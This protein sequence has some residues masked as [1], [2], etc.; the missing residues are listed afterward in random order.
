MFG[1]IGGSGFY[2]LEDLE[3]ENINNRIEIVETKYG[4]VK[5]NII[6]IENK[7][8]KIAFIPRHKKNHSIPPHKINYKANIE[9]MKKIGV[10]EAVGVYAMGI[11][12]NKKY[13]IGDII[14]LDD[15]V[16]IEKPITFFD[17]FENGIKHVDF[18][19]PFDNELKKRILKC[20]EKIGIRIKN[21]ATVKTNYGP[22][23]ETKA[24]IKLLKKLGIDLVSMTA[25][26][27]I[28]L[29]KEIGI[30]FSGIAIG[31]NYACGISKSKKPLSHEEVLELME[32]KKER[33]NLIVNE[34]VK[35][36]D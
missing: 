22:R 25:A 32:K 13:K 3:N 31:T 26:Y 34:L 11:I 36:V 1:V 2:K 18:T 24:E 30:K 29:M 9:A 20:G 14:L 23:F 28:V 6:E 15:F 33:I 19:E 5:I 27:E 8:N 10:D 35:F 4:N 21:G 12:N 16:G 7:K 17:D